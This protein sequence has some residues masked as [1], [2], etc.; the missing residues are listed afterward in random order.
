MKEEYLDSKKKHCRLMQVV[1]R[2][3][4]LKGIL[5]E[6]CFFLNVKYLDHN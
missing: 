5:A 1:L 2:A 4:T 3:T 6:K